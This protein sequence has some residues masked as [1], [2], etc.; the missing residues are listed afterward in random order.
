MLFC[1]QLI[2]FKINFFIKNLSGKLSVSSNKLYPDQ[3]KQNIGPDLGPNCLQWL[4]TY[5]PVHEI[6]KNVVCATS[7]ASDQPAH[8]RSLIRDFASRLSIQ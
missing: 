1:R 7:K 5:E 4:L 2:F 6:S 8:K 3:A